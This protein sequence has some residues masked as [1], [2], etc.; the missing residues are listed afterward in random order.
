MEKDY[1]A[2]DAYVH[3]TTTT[4]ANKRAWTGVL[5]VVELNKAV[6]F[7]IFIFPR[8]ACPLF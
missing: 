4:A 3:T 6:L 7:Y 2:L 8:A 5:F 1:T